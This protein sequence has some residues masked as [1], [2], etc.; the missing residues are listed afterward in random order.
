M[1]LVGYGLWAVDL[2]L[3]ASLVTM[4]KQVPPQLPRTTF[5]AFTLIALFFTTASIV[6]AISMSK[7]PEG[8]RGIAWGANLASVEG[9]ELKHAWDHIKEYRYTSDHPHLGNEAVE[10]VKLTTVEDKF[11]R[12][13]I[14]YQGKQTHKRILAYLQKTFGTIERI[15]GSMVRG[16]NQQFTWRGPHT[17][18]NL[19]YQGMGE[20]GFVY[21]ESR[22]LAPRFTDLLPNGAF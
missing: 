1:I 20:R 10:L 18:I 19:T 8:F 11:A 2:D 17:D 21:I 22:E 6:Q 4:M 12:V 3:R 5:F 14:R 16:L 9:L 13:H 15:P 7:D